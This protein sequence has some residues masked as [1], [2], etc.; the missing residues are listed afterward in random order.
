[1]S[2]L[3][4]DILN[5]LKK[6]LQQNLTVY[7]KLRHQQGEVMTVVK[8]IVNDDVIIVDAVTLPGL[9]LPR[10]S[11]YLDEIEHVAFARIFFNATLYA[12]LRDVKGNIRSLQEKLTGSKSPEAFYS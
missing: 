9:E 6:S 3:K 12:K 8:E 11:F 1:M 10:H 7:L 2:P 4:T 5:F